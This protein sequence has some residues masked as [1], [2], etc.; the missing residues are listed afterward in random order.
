[1]LCA[2]L[3]AC[4]DPGDKLVGTWQSQDSGYDNRLELRAD[5]TF[6]GKLHRASDAFEGNYSGTWQVQRGHYFGIFV[7]ESDFAMLAPGYSFAQEV[8]EYD[9]DRFVLRTTSNHDET[10]IRV[11]SA[12]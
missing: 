1:M 8:V 7:T 9:N 11:I 4:G 3:V 5:G 6:K 2:A 10:W 12:P